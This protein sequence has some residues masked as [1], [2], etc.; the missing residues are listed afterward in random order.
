MKFGKNKDI[1]YEINGKERD[2]LSKMLLELVAQQEAFF[3]LVR[4]IAQRENVDL[5]KVQFDQNRMAFTRLPDTPPNGV[6]G[7]R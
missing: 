5:T 2:Q 3:G 1:V 6:E 4:F 7:K